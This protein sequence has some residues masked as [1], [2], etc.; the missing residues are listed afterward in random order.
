MKSLIISIASLMLVSGCTTVPT[1]A[2]HLESQAFA[3]GEI[4]DGAPAE[5]QHWG[6]LVGQW[7]TTEES[8]KQDGSG[9]EAATGA[10]WDFFWAYNGWG[11]QD[12][13]TSPPLSEPLDDESKRQRGINLRIYNP[14]EEKWILTWLTTAS[15]Q[16]MR[17]TAT[18]ND[19]EIVMLV[20][21]LN[22]QGFHS[23]V[24]FFDMTET[25]FEW[26]M[27]WSRDEETW[28]EVHRIHGTKKSPLP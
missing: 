23:R 22:P 16:A 5:L 4:A 10:D 28:F 13:Y 20:D 6:K 14:A 17:I 12:N 27:E 24:T 19:D 18:S 9:W 11:I 26:K 15:T 3:P 25:H 2:S 7:S 8:F 1:A 21:G